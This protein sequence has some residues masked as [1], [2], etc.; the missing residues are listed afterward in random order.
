M[1]VIDQIPFNLS[2]ALI[3]Y[4]F[5]SYLIYLESLSNNA[6]QSLMYRHIA[7]IQLLSIKRKYINVN[8]IIV[9]YIITEESFKNNSVNWTIVCFNNV[10]TT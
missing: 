4:C 9:L 1:N 5:S 7:F 2:S 10:F 3:H 8:I 6:L